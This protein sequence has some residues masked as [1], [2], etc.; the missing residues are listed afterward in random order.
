MKK[1]KALLALALVAALILT[2]FAACSNSEQPQ[3]GDQAPSGTPADE[4]DYGDDEGE[5]TNIE[6]YV[7]QFS[8]TTEQYERVEDAINAIT[9]PEIGVHVKMEMFESGDYPTKLSLMM[10]GGENVDIA[11]MSFAAAGYASLYS[12]GQLMEISDLLDTYGTGIKETLGEYIYTYALGEGIYALPP[13]RAYNSTSYMI[14]RKDMLEGI[15]MTEFAENMTTWAEVEELFDAV[16][17]AYP[18]IY[19]TGGASSYLVQDSI[20]SGDTFA[21]TISYDR[22]GDALYLVYTDTAGTEPVSNVYEKPEMVQAMER[23]A[24]WMDKGYIWPDSLY[25]DEFADNLVKQNAVFCIF[26]PS[27]LGVE[28]AKAASCGYEMLCLPT[29][30]LA[31]TS[32]NVQKFGVCVPAVSDEPEAA[33]KFLNLWYTDSR[34]ANLLSWGEEG[35]DW[36]LTES[37]EA[38][39]P[40]GVDASS[41][42]FHSH[43]FMAGNQLLV[44]PWAGSGS[45]LREKAMESLAQAPVS[46]YLGFTFD[47]TE[48]NTL[49]AA[50]TSVNDEY[51][52]TL[53]S[54]GYTAEGNAEFIEKLNSV[55]LQDYL[56][57]FQ[58]QLDAWLASK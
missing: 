34:I 36:V 2:L 50:L 57:A 44:T 4:I 25:S 56:D 24:D 21:D 13:Y 27:E 5:V 11:Y 28:S 26:Q 6:M 8:G 19:P 17:T 23:A 15:G 31:V 58:T 37:G 46:A 3:S 38:D 16:K 1:F 51:A 30:N 10:S 42:G 22:L 40:E 45:D 49:V 48:Y 35:V 54:G 12:A 14:M 29:A 18:D 55:G 43:D 41:V 39:Y 7:V 47:S 33:V 9:E 20:P 32:A 53:K 52:Q